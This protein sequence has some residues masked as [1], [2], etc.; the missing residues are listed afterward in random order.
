MWLIEQHS[1][2]YCTISAVITL[3]VTIWFSHLYENYSVI[4][5]V[6]ILLKHVDFFT[7]SYW[8]YWP[9]KIA[10]HIKRRMPAI[11]QAKKWENT[12]FSCADAKRIQSMNFAYIS[13]IKFAFPKIYSEPKKNS[14]KIRK[15][16]NIVQPINCRQNCRCL[17]C[18]F[19]W[20]WKITLN[21]W[22]TPKWVVC[23]SLSYEM[24]CSIADSTTQICLRTVSAI[25]RRNNLIKREHVNKWRIS[26]SVCLTRLVLSGKYLVNKY[27]NI[28]EKNV[29]KKKMKK[30]Q[31]VNRLNDKKK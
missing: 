15:L 22:W 21:S 5:I 30:K 1:Q 6:L 4:S 18:V 16:L 28:T 20:L 14:R 23:Q 2:E 3:I 13:L 29:I 31:Y 11:Q 17:V 25:V 9:F 8:P 19:V 7:H 27:K 12:Y 24:Y 10:L 26:V